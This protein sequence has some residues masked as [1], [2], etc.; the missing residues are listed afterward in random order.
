MLALLNRGGG[1]IPVHIVVRQ[2]LIAASA[3]TLALAVYRLGR[4]AIERM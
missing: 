4:R 3:V 2:M 1:E